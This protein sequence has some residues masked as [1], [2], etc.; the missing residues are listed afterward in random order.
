MKSIQKIAWNAP[1]SEP[2]NGA[3]CITDTF[4]CAEE[5]ILN[6]PANGN[7]APFIK[8][9]VKVCVHIHIQYRTILIA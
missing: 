2:L 8:R 9:Y 3:F 7:I 5:W 4:F 6:C 1:R